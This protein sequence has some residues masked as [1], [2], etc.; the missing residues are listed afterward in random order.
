MRFFSKNSKNRPLKH[1]L[2]HNKSRPP[3][4]NVKDGLLKIPVKIKP[5]RDIRYL[6]MQRAKNV[7][8]PCQSV[9]GS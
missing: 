7:H 3:G 8:S 9:A 5:V 6:F 1:F 2:F 4:L